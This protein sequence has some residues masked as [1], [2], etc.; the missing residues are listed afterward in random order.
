[1]QVSTLPTDNL[2]KFVALSGVA[3]FLASGYLAVTNQLRQGDA[4][5]ELHKSD[6]RVVAQQDMVDRKLEHIDKRIIPYETPPDSGPLESVPEATVS[7][8]RQLLAEVE[9]DHVESGKLMVANRIERVDLKLL[10]S[11]YETIFWLCVF[12]M[13]L[14]AAV[15]IGGFFLW[16]VRLQRPLDAQLQANSGGDSDGA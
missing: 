2:Y 8:L 13:V 9:A 3:I 5:R 12:G 14:G 11:R 10:D 6:L 7:A 4:W 16:Y 15:A 1:M